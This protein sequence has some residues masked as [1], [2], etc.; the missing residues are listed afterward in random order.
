MN[1]VLF[2]VAVYD[3]FEFSWEYC[4]R[5]IF[6]VVVVSLVMSKSFRIYVHFQALIISF[7]CSIVGHLQLTLV[8]YSGCVFDRDHAHTV[9]MPSVHHIWLVVDFPCA[10]G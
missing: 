5:K 9:R 1:I 4:C 6:R 8:C 10:G 3:H 7:Q 2:L